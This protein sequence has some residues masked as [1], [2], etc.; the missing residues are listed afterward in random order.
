MVVVL[1]DVLVDLLLRGPRV[2]AQR[3]LVGPVV[4]RVHV[5]DHGGAGPEVHPAPLA[6]VPRHGV[7]QRVH[8][9]RPSPG[10]VERPEAGPAGPGHLS[11]STAWV[12][13]EASLRFRFLSSSATTLHCLSLESLGTTYSHLLHRR[14][15]ALWQ[16][17]G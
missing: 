15:D 10:R 1:D 11:H 2:A 3:A 6:L 4:A 14:D 9:L 7:P 17:G 16:I 13:G 5:P 12:W 8:V